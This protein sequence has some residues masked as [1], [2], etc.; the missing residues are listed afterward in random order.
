MSLE[1]DEFFPTRNICSIQKHAK[2][3][4]SYTTVSL[5]ILTVTQLG[6]TVKTE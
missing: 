1:D 6:Y 3:P 4:G 5:L 2:F